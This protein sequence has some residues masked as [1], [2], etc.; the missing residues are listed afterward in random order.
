[1]ET[2]KRAR[3]LKNPD[4]RKHLDSKMSGNL[5]TTSQVFP[6]QTWFQGGVGRKKGKSVHFALLPPSGPCSY[7]TQRFLA[8]VLSWSRN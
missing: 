5:Q 6:E 3:S 1:M 7:K 2:R 8:S 4:M